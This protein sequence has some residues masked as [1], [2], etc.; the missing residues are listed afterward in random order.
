MIGNKLK[1]DP[2]DPRQGVFF[3][4]ERRRAVR[5]ES[6]IQARMHELFF[7]VPPLPAGTY[8]LEVRGYVYHS[9]DVRS[10]QLAE[11]LVVSY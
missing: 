2:G 11:T 8:H 1:F 6:M 9:P 3:V 7:K 4:D 10:G 5:V